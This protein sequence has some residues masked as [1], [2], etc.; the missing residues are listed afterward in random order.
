MADY[1]SN[2]VEAY[3]KS[4][5]CGN[6]IYE[7]QLCKTLEADYQDDLTVF[8][9]ATRASEPDPNSN[10]KPEYSSKR[11]GMAWAAFF[12][13][14]LLVLVLIY[15]PEI[16]AYLS[17]MVSATAAAIIVAVLVV[18]LIA[19]IITLTVLE[20]DWLDII[21]NNV[22]QAVS[23]VTDKVS[24]SLAT[25]LEATGRGIGGFFKGASVVLLLA[26]A[27]TLLYFLLKPEQP[28]GS[29]V[30]RSGGTN[31]E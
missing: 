18:V 4:L 7:Y 29:V 2:M 28:Q 19:V 21:C 11:K 10:P 9:V 27:G 15:A 23:T 3:F 16:T 24:D 17:T 12:M 1:N 25:L 26:G 8:T 14:C 13:I 6:H 31:N 22:G 20:P 5:Q 30:I